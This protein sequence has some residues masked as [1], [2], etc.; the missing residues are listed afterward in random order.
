LSTVGT[1]TGLPRAR[2]LSAEGRH[3]AD[4]EIAITARHR[5]RGLLGRSGLPPGQ[6]MWLAPARSIHTIGMQFPIDVV[7]LDRDSR[8][9]A[10]RERVAPFRLTWGGWR[11]RGVLE[12]AA[13]E[14]QRLNITGGQQLLMQPV[15]G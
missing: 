7:Y 15:H 11:S 6:A 8:V 10:I 1:A 9:V 2:L 4:V 3:L 12:F 14:V 13:G 5:A